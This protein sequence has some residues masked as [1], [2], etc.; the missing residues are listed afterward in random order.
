MKSIYIA[1]LYLIGAL[2]ESCDYGEFYEYNDK[3]MFNCEYNGNYVEIDT[4]SFEQI[5]SECEN[6]QSAFEDGICDSLDDLVWRDDECDCPY[7]EC[8]SI[9]SSYEKT[10]S[11]SPYLSCDLLTCGEIPNYYGNLTDTV[12]TYDNA[13]SVSSAAE[14]SYWSC[15]PRYRPGE[16]RPPVILSR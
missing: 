3:C 4:L 7:C 2:S 6:V 9:T 5:A 8:S 15:P 14:Y 12:Y 11:F 16:E 1:P 10:I 13:I